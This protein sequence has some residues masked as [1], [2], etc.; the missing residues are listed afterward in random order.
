MSRSPSAQSTA[1]DQDAYAQAWRALQKL[2]KQGK[3]E[4][5][6][7]RNCLFLN[8]G[9]STDATRERFAS[10]SATTG[11]DFPDDGR[12][13]ATV[14]WDHDGRLDLWVT[15]RTAPRVRLMLNRFPSQ[16]NAWLSLRL[17]GDGKISNRDAVGARV[18]VHVKGKP[19][20]LLRTVTAGV[21]FLSQSSVWLSFGLGK[22]PV[23][24]KIVV[25]WPGGAAE[26]FTGAAPQGFYTL[27]Q[28]TGKAKA[29]SP[30]DAPRTWREQPYALPAEATEA[31]RIL[32]LDPHPLPESFLPAPAGKAGLLV[33]FWS[34][35]CPNCLGQLKD[36]G[37]A[38]EKFAAAGVAVAALCVDAS[39]ADAVQAARLA[40]FTTTDQVSVGKPEHMA[41]FNALQLSATGLQK[42]MPAPTTFLLNSKRQITAIYKG[43]V[44]PDQ[45]LKDLSLLELSAAERRKLASPEKAGQWL[46]P[47]AGSSLRT[48]ATFIEEGLKA[49]AAQILEAAILHSNTPLPTGAAEHEVN[50]R[51]LEFAQC[52]RL[53][54][55]FDTEKK[56]FAKAEQRYRLSLQALPTLPTRRELAQLYAGLRN[57]K[58]YPA[59]MREYEEIL[60]L[61]RNPAEL[62]RLAVL[63]LETGSPAEAIPLLQESLRFAPDAG[64]QFQLGIALR[65]IGRAE[66]AAEAWNSCLKLNPQYWPA[67]NN[68]AWLRATHPDKSLRNGPE[69][70]TLSNIATKLTQK[71]NPRVL[72]TLAV[73]YT[74]VGDFS[75][76]EKVMQEALLLLKSNK[77]E[78]LLKLLTTWNESIRAKK[79]IRE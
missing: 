39:L 7:E 23:L 9:A 59:L 16:E 12:G 69:A 32:P 24:E 58:L 74:A 37:P 77:D 29:W 45:L 52:Q 11:L 22:D 48:A 31:A 13:S 34:V 61:D 72:A 73:S 17:T 5:G 3:S 33:N 62:G 28:S 35:D 27:E 49:Q 36:W 46:E 50:W 57:P 70:V 51:R 60:K 10:V 14:D 42:P 40:G 78:P 76:A 18:E 75:L 66:E 4:S 38:A 1:E 2:L 54:A 68:L 20:P 21:G 56:D 26:T 19:A 63:K 65:T 79:E 53:L 67:A 15:N 43:P 44:S 30:P 41:I 6:L 64:H 47:L 8:L 25:K 71:G 55:K